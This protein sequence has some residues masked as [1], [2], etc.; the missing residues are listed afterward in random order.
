MLATT[1][2]SATL[3]GVDGHLVSVE[4][5]LSNGLPSFTVV[6]LPDT[7]CRE[8]RD[9]VRA[10]V[11]S[12]GLEWPQRRLTVNRA[13]SGLRKVGSVLDLAIA[14]GV[15]A[16]T[17]QIPAEAAERWAFLGELGLDGGVR[18]IGGLV[19]LVHA[20]DGRDLVIPAAGH[21]VASR[22]PRAGRIEV[23]RSLSDAVEALTARAPW[24][25]PPVAEVCPPVA[26]G[27]DMSDV[28]GHPQGRLACEV[29]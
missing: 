28:V 3:L 17:E 24:P 10:A 6:G 25:D 27:P 8:S 20:L 7:A 23:V 29:A 5:H 11:L 19:P 15:L 4:V 26:D 13:P 9:R 16:V 14:I 2:M 18:P 1:T 12:S 21:A 22:V